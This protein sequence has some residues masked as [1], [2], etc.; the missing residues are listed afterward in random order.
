V[1]VAALALAGCADDDGAADFALD[2]SPRF[3]DDEGVVTSVSIGELELDDDRTYGMSVELESFSTYTMELEP[4]LGWDG[5][6]VQVGLDGDTVVWIA[7]VADVF[8]GPPLTAYYTGQLVEIDADRKL[9]FRDGTVLQLADG[10][11]PAA[12]EGSVVVEI[13][14][15]AHRAVDVQPT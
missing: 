6:Y 8:P 13:D 5:H 7:G 12:D 15:A 11:R 1:T 10:V 2:G 14:A 4:V 3:P 9:V